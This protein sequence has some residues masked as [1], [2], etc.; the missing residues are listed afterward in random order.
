MKQAN[1]I[2]CSVTAAQSHSLHQVA[3]EEKNTK[4]VIR[5]GRED[6]VFKYAF[7]NCFDNDDDRY[8]NVDVD[9]K[10]EDEGDDDDYY[11]VEG[12]RFI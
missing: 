12:G 8:E 4:M 9:D 11:E 3:E 2:L 5:E 1:D 6:D 10:L 7:R